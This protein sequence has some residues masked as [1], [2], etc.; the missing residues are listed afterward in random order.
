MTTMFRDSDEKGQCVDGEY[1]WTNSA[2]NLHQIKPRT[3][4]E[5]LSLATEKHR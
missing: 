5:R 2:L 1:W 3:Y 4:V